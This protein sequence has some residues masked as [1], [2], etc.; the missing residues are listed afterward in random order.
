L[1]FG[2]VQWVADVILRNHLDAQHGF[3]LQTLK[4]ANTEAARIALM[5]GSADVVVTDWTMVASQRAAGNKL[6]FAPFSSA[7]GGIMVRQDSPARTLADLKDRTLGVAGGPLDKSWLIVRAAGQAQG[8]DL[9]SAS[10][11]V[12][13]A[14]PLLAAKLQQGELDAALTYWN[15]AAK[16]EAV[17]FRQM[18]SV[19][20]CARD[21]GLPSHLG[22]LGFVFHEDWANQ[23]RPAIDGF[24]DAAADAERRLAD[25][26]SEWQAVRPLMSA[27][28]NAL[29]ASLKRRFIEGVAHPSAKEEQRTAERVFAILTQ[30]GGAEAA[31]G[32]SKL[33]DG[34]FW[35]VPNADR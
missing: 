13:G 7:V 33:P 21:L 8:V 16:L 2:T 31:D 18:L 35:P 15:F 34:I 4:L 30:T 27:P 17:G 5:A 19:A 28:D 23:N 26:E 14:S 1:Q 29:F 9:A 10:H 20:D 3:T 6:C 11:I 25:S 32:L 24:L 22:L 12:Y